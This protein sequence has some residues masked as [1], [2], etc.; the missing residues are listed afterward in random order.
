MWKDQSAG[1]IGHAIHRAT[2]N[3][4]KNI[5]QEIK[6]MSKPKPHEIAA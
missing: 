2:T 4:A 3:K 1:I 5:A 6:N